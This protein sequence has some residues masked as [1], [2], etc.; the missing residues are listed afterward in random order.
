MK[1]S[2]FS[3][4]TETLVEVLRLESWLFHSIVANEKKKQKQNLK[5]LCFVLIRGILPIVL[6]AYGCTS[7]RKEIKKVFWMFIFENFIEEAKF[8]VPMSKLKGFQA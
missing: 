5:K 3:L 7:Y 4:R 2:T 8:S 6:E 1:S